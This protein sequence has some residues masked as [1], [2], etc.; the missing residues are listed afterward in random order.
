MP[1]RIRSFFN[2]GHRGAPLLA[3]PGNTVAS[4]RRAAEA[5][6]QML[7]VDVRRTRDDVLILEH[8][9][10]RMVGGRDTLIRELSYAQ[11]QAQALD[12]APLATLADAFAVAAHYG[13][14]LM[15]DFKEPGT[16]ALIARAVRHSGIPLDALLIA[17][18]NET[19]RKILRSLDPR[20][21]LSLSLGPEDKA[22]ITASL[23]GEI[24]TDAVTWH[25]SLITPAL[26]AVLNKREILV[27]AWTVDLA[28]E[29]RRLRDV[30]HVD[31]IITNAPDLL[32]SLP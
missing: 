31:G 21:P 6:A 12:N 30:C 29:M 32:R 27:Y 16:E 17:G 13:L 25:Y 28:D 24:D 1:I 4:L 8:D 10:M 2:I 15:L 5:G 9:A 11:W 19:S 20:L 26:V 23:L 18:A 7:E 14:G 3:S 22:R